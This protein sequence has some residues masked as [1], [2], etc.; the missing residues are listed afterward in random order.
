MRKENKKNVFLFIFLD[1]ILVNFHSCVHCLL[2]VGLSMYFCPFVCLSLCPSNHVFV[3]P[4]IN[5]NFIVNFCIYN[6][7][8]AEAF[9]YSVLEFGNS[10][11]F[12]NMYLSK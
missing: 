12:F 3:D 9:D 7:K 5:D 1:F 6:S 8:F 4:S 11:M 2:S 10:F